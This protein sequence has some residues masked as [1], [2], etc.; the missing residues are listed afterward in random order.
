M[1]VLP[2]RIKPKMLKFEAA[3]SAETSL[4]FRKLFLSWHMKETKPVC[5]NK[6]VFDLVEMNSDPPSQRLLSAPSFLLSGSI[7]AAVSRGINLYFLS[8]GV[9]AP[10][11][12][13]KY[14]DSAGAFHYEESGKLLSVTSNRFIHW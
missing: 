12:G 7:T 11:G 4:E 8:A 2:L 1:S 6:N 14:A 9:S 10:P 5:N 13:L 3:A